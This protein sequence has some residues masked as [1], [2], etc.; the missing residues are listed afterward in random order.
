MHEG[1]DVYY[2][3]DS[4]LAGLADAFSRASPPLITLRP[5]LTRERHWLPGSVALAETGRAV[6]AGQLDK[7]TTCGIDRWFGGVH[8]QSGRNIWRWDGGRQR[9]G[10]S[11][12]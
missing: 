1:E 2:I 10:R 6:L 4:S 11:A 5:D 8:L 12:S 9:V 3:T 7:I